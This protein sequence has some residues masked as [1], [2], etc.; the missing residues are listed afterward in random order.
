MKKIS[1]FIVLLFLFTMM[2]GC[3]GMTRLEMD[4]GTSFNLAKYNQTLNPDAEKNLD[5]V[6]GMD[7]WAAAAAMEKYHKGFEK[8]ADAQAT[9]YTL[10]IGAMGK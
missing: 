2:A 10:N 9:S 3:A 6:Y 4:Y 8:P 5:P 1:I 7:G